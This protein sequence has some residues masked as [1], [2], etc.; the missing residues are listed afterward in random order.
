MYWCPRGSQNSKF[1]HGCFIRQTYLI[2]AMGPNTKYHKVSQSITEYWGV[3]ALSVVFKESGTDLHLCSVYYL[4][5]QYG[6]RMIFMC[7]PQQT[8]AVNLYVQMS[9]TS[10][11]ATLGAAFSSWGERALVRGTAER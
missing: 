6:I 7:R 1:H 5:T 8:V 11:A 3:G 2:I 10:I 4:F 9:L